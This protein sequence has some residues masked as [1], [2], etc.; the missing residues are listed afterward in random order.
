MV[1][2]GLGV[3]EAMMIALYTGF[4]VPA[5]TAV[6]VVLAFRV[7]AFWMPNLLGFG[8]IPLLQIPTRKT[9]G[10]LP[11]RRENAGV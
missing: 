8:I 11:H 2:G 7:I 4:G 5:A 6:T 1:P 3:V 9:G 10:D